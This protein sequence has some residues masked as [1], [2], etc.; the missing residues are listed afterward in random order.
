[1]HPWYDPSQPRH[2]FPT[3]WQVYTSGQAEGTLIGGNISTFNLIK[4]TEFAP[5]PKDYV[6]FLEEA[7]DDDSVTILQHITAIL[8][9]YPNPKAVCL[10]RFPKE[11]DMST[12][13]LLFILDKY[14]ILK[15]IPVLYDLDLAHT[16]PLFTFTIG[17]TIN[18]DTE[19][20]NL[21]IKE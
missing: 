3:K 10:G 7:E 17:A 2:F 5:K 9:A 14:P 6:L 11:C 1:M 12:E 19:T 21:N 8:Q 18:I 20:F 15:E 13:K 16:Q 4:G